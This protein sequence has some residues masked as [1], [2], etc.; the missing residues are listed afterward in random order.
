MAKAL[1][2]GLLWHSLQSGNLGVGALTVG[3]MALIREAAERAGR[4]VEFTILQAGDSGP[5]Y[6]GE[7]HPRFVI[8][9]RS[10]LTS[11]RFLNTVRGLDMVAD[12][13]GGDSFAQIYGPKRFTFLMA[14]KA[15]TIASGVPLVL[16]PQ[17]YG[18]YTSQPYR[19]LAA[20]AIRKAALVVA[21]DPTSQRVAQELSARE[22]GLA[23]DVAFRLPYT[24]GTERGAFC[25]VNVSGLLWTDAGHGAIR[26]P[27]GYDYR[28]ATRKIIAALL[29][30]GETVKLF[31]HATSTVDPSDDDSAVA[32]H[33][34]TE[35]PQVERVPDFAHPS[36]A[37]SFVSSAKLVVSARMH[38]C[39][40]GFATGVPTVPL[41]YSRK[42]SGLLGET[43]GYGEVV[44]VDTPGADAVV[45]ATLS[46]LD[47]HAE[48]AAAI[49]AGNARVDDLLE[50]YITRLA[51]LMERCP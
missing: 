47:R 48:V 16:S 32:D 50:P 13:G 39:I 36:E 11:A 8:D 31:A 22:V 44:D 5:V 3:N 19:G 42:F 12:I 45:A 49:A 9:R 10:T 15:M 41:A 4:A 25:A 17:T 7:D 20:W 27:L 14:T 37:K 6:P 21:R 35:F 40:A 1:K 18:P 51:A 29:D 34:A 24:Q 46:V 28:D 23:T 33:V 30:R 26:F 2:V 38:A 43:L